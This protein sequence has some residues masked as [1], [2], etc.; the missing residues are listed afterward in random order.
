MKPTN[1]LGTTG[2]S[3]GKTSWSWVTYNALLHDK[4]QNLQV[5]EWPNGEGFTVIRNDEPEIHIDWG[6]WGAL[7]T[8]V[9]KLGS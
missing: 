5:V 3:T 4:E 9:T 6:E 7:K 8:A 2:I 1:K